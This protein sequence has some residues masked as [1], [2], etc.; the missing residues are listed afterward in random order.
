M[1]RKTP[2]P[3]PSGHASESRR[4]AALNTKEVLRV[5]PSSRSP[6]KSL[7]F[8]FCRRRNQGFTHI[9]L[10]WLRGAQHPGSPAQEHSH[11]HIHNG[12]WL[13]RAQGS[14]THQEGS[15]ELKVTALA[16]GPTPHCDSPLGS[17]RHGRNSEG[18]GRSHGLPEQTRSDPSKAPSTERLRTCA[19]E[20]QDLPLP[21]RSL[22]S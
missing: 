11:P 9:K 16:P 14:R 4:S 18:P 20:A 2:S 8:P 17:A 5:S 19:G 13:G 7:F 1:L 21:R 10:V 3:H 12:A 22:G 6:A 15:Q